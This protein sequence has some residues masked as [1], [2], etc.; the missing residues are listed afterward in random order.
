MT[1]N[2]DYINNLIV[3]ITEMRVSHLNT[4]R[5]RCFNNNKDNG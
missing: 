3:N 2:R 1:V 4:V 5:Y